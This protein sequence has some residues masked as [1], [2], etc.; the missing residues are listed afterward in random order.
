MMV[1]WMR[2]FGE[3]GIPYLPTPGRPVRRASRSSS[4]LAQG[5]LWG[6]RA[7]AGEL[8]ISRFSFQCRR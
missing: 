7:V 6:T 2:W 4:E 8:A 1:G 5:R 3:G